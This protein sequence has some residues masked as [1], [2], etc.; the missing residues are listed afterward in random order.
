[1]SSPKSKLEFISTG[2]AACRGGLRDVLLSALPAQGGLWVPAQI[3]QLPPGF[4]TQ[5]RHATYAE[6]AEAVV[7]PYFAE[8]LGAEVLHQLCQEA[9][10][11]PVPLIS[12]EKFKGTPA[13]KIAVLELFQGPSAAFKDF[14]V[15]LLVRVTARVLGNEFPQLTV[16]AATSG[17]TGAAVTEA[18]AGVPGVRAVVLYPRGGRAQ[19]QP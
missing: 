2:D 13:E 15:R 3:P 16:L 9:F 5:V 10:N 12:P 14:A 18:C 19:A 4:L 6:L 7:A 8:E 1:M 11:F 17:D